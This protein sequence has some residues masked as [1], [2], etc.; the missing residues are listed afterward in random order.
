MALSKKYILSVSVQEITV[1]SAFIC[2]TSIK[3]NSLTKQTFRHW[4]TVK[5]FN[6]AVNCLS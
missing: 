4:T 5:K 2:A 1:K 3:N 6:D